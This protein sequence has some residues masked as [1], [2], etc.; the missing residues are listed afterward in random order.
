MKLKKSIG[1]EVKHPEKACT[2][3]H[4]PFHSDLAIRGRILEGTVT[5]VDTFKTAKIQFIRFFYLPKYERYEKRMTKLKVHVPD[6]IQ[7]KSGD[8]VKVAEC[9]PISKTKNFV[10]V[11]VLK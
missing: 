2:D 9:R 4:C 5:K 6:C 11:E 1:I 7:L 10:V 8:L 3:K